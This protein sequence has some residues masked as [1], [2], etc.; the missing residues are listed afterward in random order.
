MA[1]RDETTERDLP[2]V[3]DNREKHVTVVTDDGERHDHDDTFLRY[4]DDTFIVSRDPEFAEAERSTY[5]KEDVRRLEVTQHHTACFITTATAGEGETLNALRGFRDD[6]LEPTPAGRALV[7]VYYTVSPPVARTLE[8][9]PDARTTRFVRWLVER[10]ADLA[11][12]REV[13]SP[14][15]GAALTVCL[16]LL[17]VV[18][19]LAA[20]LGHLGIRLRELTG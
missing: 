3:G 15:A 20:T 19:V 11:E 6:A 7:R 5:R 10:C 12:T 2:G 14:A 16:T 1:A 4:T 9:H 8:R 17:Y 18:G 13:A